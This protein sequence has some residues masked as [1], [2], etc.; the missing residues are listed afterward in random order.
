[1]ISIKKSLTYSFLSLGFIF[2]MYATLGVFIGSVRYDEIFWSSMSWML[3]QD[4]IAVEDIYLTPLYGRVLSTLWQLGDGQIASFLHSARALSFALYSSTILLLTCLLKKIFFK[5]WPEGWICASFIA[6]C[7]GTYLAA[8]RGFEIR[9]EALGNFL[10]VSGATFLIFGDRS[11]K[12]H[13]YFLYIVSIASLCIASFVT[14]RHSIP[15]VFLALS[16]TIF[17]CKNLNGKAFG[18]ALLTTFFLVFFVLACLDYY[19]VSLHEFAKN[20]IDW[21]DPRSPT[22]F[23]YKLLSLGLW[24]GMESV[25]PQRLW[26]VI[27]LGSILIYSGGAALCV[28]RID[29]N[30]A[31]VIASLLLGAALSI[32]LLL[33]ES[34]PF[35]YV[36]SVEGCV[37]LILL[38]ISASR[39]SGHTNKLVLSSICIFA[40]LGMPQAIERLD[41]FRSTTLAI[42]SYYDNKSLVDEPNRFSFEQAI[43]QSGFG[44]SLARQVELRRVICAALQNKKVFVENYNSHPICVMDPLSR[45]FAWLMELTFDEQVSAIR[46]GGKSVEV[47]NTKSGRIAVY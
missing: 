36:V 43:A 30:T 22:S 20:L 6:V 27:L 25:E 32:I 24:K 37:F 15:S 19:V 14:I 16:S 1:M 45:D 13:F 9:P 40:T 47:F 34:V 31:W 26:R 33:Y 3:Y 42:N 41:Y 17:L 46:N 8:V 28:R 35:N 12:N 2:A 11:S 7:F 21:H 18:V 29:K 39:S 23:Q 44:N 5:N 10:Y 4:A 38:L